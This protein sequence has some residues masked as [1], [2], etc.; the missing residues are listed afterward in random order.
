[1]ILEELRHKKIAVLSGG[2]S[3]EREISLK[4]GQAVLAALREKGL[5]A[6]GMD[7][8]HRLPERLLRERVDVVFIALHG[9]YGEDGTIQGLL[10]LLKIPYTGSGVLAS[11]LAMDKWMAKK[12]FSFHGVPTPDCRL[13]ERGGDRAALMDSVQGWYP[14]V[15]KPNQEGSTLGVSIIA[16]TEALEAALEEALCYDHRI[17]VER[18]VPGREITVSVFEG[19]AFP[20]LEIRPKSGFYDFT[21][22]YTSGKTEYLL[23]APLGQS[24]NGEIE[25]LAVLAY[26]ALQCDGAARVDF[27]LDG[28]RP[29]CLEINT[30][31]G[32]TETSLLPKAATYAGI[33]F[34]DLVVRMLEKASLKIGLG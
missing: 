10:E 9:R 3:A 21:S 16:G 26:T 5:A 19:K 11:S 2:Y 28:E 33:P 22:K 6:L 31:P 25:K 29:Y 34:A 18:F 30:I 14:L 27:I 15:V 8:D 7:A 24:L 20:A 32:M 13:F 1:M 4:T 12:L 23:P 17:L